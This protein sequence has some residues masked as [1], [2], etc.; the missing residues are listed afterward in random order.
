MALAA[1]AVLALAVPEQA[2]AQTVTTFIS[3]SA[4]V[5]STASNLLRATAFTTGGNS[6]GYELSSVDVYVST[7]TATPTPLVEIYEDNAGNPG[8]LH[9]TLSNP[10]ALTELSANTFNAPL[11]TTLNASTTYWLVVSNSASTD[12]RG[13]RV[14]TTLNNATADTGAATGWSIG[15][16]RAR[17]GSISNWTSSNNR[18]IFTIKGPLGTTTAN[19][20]PVFATATASRSFTETVGDAAVSTAGNVGAV[21]TA[22]DADSD[23]LTY[24]LEGTDGAKFGIVSSSGQIRTKVGEKYDREAEASYSVT[25]KAI[26]GNGGSD[27][28]AVTITVDNVVEKPVA[29]AMPAVTATSGSTTSLDVSWTAPDNTGRPAITGYKVEYRP[30]VSGNWITHAHTGTGTTTTIASRTAATAYQVQVLAVNSDGDGPF[31]SPGAGTTGT[32]TNTAPV[33][34]SSNVARSVAENTAAGQNVGAAVTATDADTGD[35]L[36]YTLGGTDMASFDIV[37][38]SGQIRTK[39]G[40]SYDFETKDPYTVTVTASDGT[41]TAVAS[42]TISTTDVAEPPVVERPVAEPPDAPAMPTVSAVAGTTTSLTVSWA[43]PANAG[44]P[45]ISQLRRA[46]PSGQLRDLDRRPAGC[47][48]HDHDRYRPRRGHAL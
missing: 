18:L 1:L 44:K 13:F 8:T 38:D 36:A 29:P 7:S 27:T 43:T 33:F 41:A 9:A 40:V 46:V 45:P 3:N 21:V 11:N 17:A 35:S 26:D 23:T 6:G 42:V 32:A 24:S 4:Q 31:S 48:G 20:A 2:E 10:A 39:S 5:G 47:H 15:N 19:N 34:S 22:T 12:G 37:G 16:A 30:G 25:V 28:I 14:Y